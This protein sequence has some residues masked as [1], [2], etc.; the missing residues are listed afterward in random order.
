MIKF[1]PKRFKYNRPYVKKKKD[2]E[3]KFF[4]NV[5]IDSYQ[6]GFISLQEVYVFKDEAMSI[7]RYLKKALDKKMKLKFH[8]DFVNAYTSKS[9]GMR[10]G[11]GKGPRREF[12]SIVKNGQMFLEIYIDKKMTLKLKKRIQKVLDGLIKRVSFPIKDVWISY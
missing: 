8:L 4:T 11:K 5:H 3:A 1:T 10:M 9:V 2:R 12:F 7:Y 6:I